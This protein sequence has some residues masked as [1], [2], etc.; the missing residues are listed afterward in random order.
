MGLSF[1]LSPVSACP[2][3]SPRA[4]FWVLVTGAQPLNWHLRSKKAHPMMLIGGNMQCGVA[5][6]VCQAL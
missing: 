6:I 3:R 2:G 1:I 4:L 5:S